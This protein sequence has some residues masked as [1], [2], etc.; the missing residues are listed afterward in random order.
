MSA[1]S[2]WQSNQVRYLLQYFIS[3]PHSLTYVTANK[4]VNSKIATLS[5]GIN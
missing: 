4:N 5:F 3:N 1:K 2:K